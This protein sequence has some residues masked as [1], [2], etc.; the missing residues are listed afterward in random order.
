MTELREL[1]EYGG[2]T[3][4]LPVST[5]SQLCGGRAL[6]SFALAASWYPTLLLMSSCSAELPLPAQP[7]PIVLYPAARFTMVTHAH[8]SE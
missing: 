2:P 3:T 5:G 6:H 4:G 8:L 7:F 1:V